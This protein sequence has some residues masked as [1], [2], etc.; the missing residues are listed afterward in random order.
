MNKGEKFKRVKISKQEYNKLKKVEEQIDSK[1]AYRRIQAFKLIHKRWKYSAI[2]E[3]INVTNET[4]SDWIRLYK[5]GGINGLVTLCYKGGQ[6]K[7][8]EKQLTELRK[9]ASEG[10]FTF[11]KDIQNY[12]ENNFKIKYGLRHVQLLSKKNFTYPLNKLD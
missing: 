10:N 2:A 7:L 12:I 1:K 11:A 5:K 9:K 8:N 6:Q 3:F 4:I